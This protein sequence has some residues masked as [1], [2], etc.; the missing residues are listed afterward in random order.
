MRTVI[1]IIS[2]IFVVG[3]TIVQPERTPNEFEVQIKVVYETIKTSI[4]TWQPAT[5]YLEPSN[6]TLK[7]VRASLEYQGDV[8]AVLQ[9]D[10]SKKLIVPKNRV[11]V[12]LYKLKE[13]E[14]N[15]EDRTPDG[16]TYFHS[17]LTSNDTTWY[18][19]HVD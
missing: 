16:A 4:G 19:M 12:A 15:V 8:I 18:L 5:I 9:P 17:L 10:S 11:I 3:C 2:M 6:R 7:E 14:H 1:T 13:H